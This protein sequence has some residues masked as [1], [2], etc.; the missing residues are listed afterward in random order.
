MVTD[1]KM[2]VIK[3]SASRKIIFSRIAWILIIFVLAYIYI[4]AESPYRNAY[5]TSKDKYPKTDFLLAYPNWLYLFGL[6]KYLFY[7]W[8]LGESKRI[9]AIEFSYSDGG[10]YHCP[11]YWFSIKKETSELSKIIY[12]IEIENGKYSRYNYSLSH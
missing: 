4:G 10:I 8:A 12:G 3:T 2:H 6:G 5:D 11:H 9:G 1:D 7:P